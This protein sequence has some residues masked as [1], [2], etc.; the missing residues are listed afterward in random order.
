MKNHKENESARWTIEFLKRNPE[1]EY[2]VMDDIGIALNIDTMNSDQIKELNRRHKAIKK[3][4][5]HKEYLYGLGLFVFHILLGV[6]SKE[7]LIFAISGFLLS[8]ITTYVLC[9]LK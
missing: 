9:K 2:Q 5:K 7:I 4:K 8:A 1:I 3:M 6:L